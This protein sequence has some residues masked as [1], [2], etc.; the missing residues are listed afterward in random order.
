MELCTSCHGPVDQLKPA[1]TARLRQLYPDDRGT[2]YSVGQ[3][4]GAIT[5]RQPA[6]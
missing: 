3:I 6:P 2:G 1:V 4:R 5:L